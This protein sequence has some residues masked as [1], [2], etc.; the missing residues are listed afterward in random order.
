MNLELKRTRTN[1][2]VLGSYIAILGLARNSK[3]QGAAEK[4][5]GG[6]MRITLTEHFEQ[7]R[8]RLLFIDK[9]GELYSQATKGIRRTPRRQEP[10]KDAISCEKP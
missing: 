4:C 7:Q 2:L 8:S 5:G 6:V 1:S 9:S 10:K 3:M